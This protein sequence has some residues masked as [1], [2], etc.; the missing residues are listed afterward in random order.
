MKKKTKTRL[1]DAIADL[2]ERIITRVGEIEDFIIP[3]IEATAR[4]LVMH[5]RL[6]EE[7]METDLQRYATGSMDQVKIEAN[8]LLAQYEKLH[9]SLTDDLTALGLN[10]NTTPSKVTENT[11]K[12]VDETDPM[13]AFYS[14]AT[15]Q[16]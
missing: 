14:N 10:Y 4:H 15:K 9:R 16:R 7:L 6:W 1:A 5:D 12:G 13:A 3:Q 2:R 11:K 8:P